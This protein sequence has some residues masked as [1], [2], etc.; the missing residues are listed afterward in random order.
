MLVAEAG[1]RSVMRQA[2]VIGP[3]LSGC[4]LLTQEG[5]LDAGAEPL[6]GEAAVLRRD[7]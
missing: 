5:D 3:Q 4:G 2:C 7:F 1:S 6:E